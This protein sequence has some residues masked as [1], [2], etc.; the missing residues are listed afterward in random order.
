MNHSLTT[1]IHTKFLFDF[2]KIGS[3]ILRSYSHRLMRITSLINT[4]NYVVEL[5]SEMC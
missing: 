1:H 4:V 2:M 5:D 3:D